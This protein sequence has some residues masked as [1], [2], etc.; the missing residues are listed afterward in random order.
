MKP[1]IAAPD[2]LNFGN[3]LK[4][5]TKQIIFT[6]INNGDTA[7]TVNSF[8]FTSDLF[9]PD[10]TLV[11]PF[12]IASADSADDI[13]LY[14][15][16]DTEQTDTTTLQIW[17]NDPWQPAFRIS[18]AGRGVVPKL[19]VLPQN[20][21]F[22]SVAVGDSL[23]ETLLLSNK[24]SGTLKSA[25]PTITGTDAAMFMLTADSLSFTIPEGDTTR[26]EL[27]VQ[28]KPVSE[29][30]KQAMLSIPTNNPDSNLTE[31]ELTGFGSL[32]EISVSD[33]IIDFNSVYI[34]ESDSQELVI[35]NTG[36]GDL[37]IKDL[38]V[39]GGDSAHFSVEGLNVDNLVSA[40][41]ADTLVI[42][43]NPLP[44]TEG[45]K[46]ASLIVASNDP[47]RNIT[48]IRLLGNSVSP[49]TIQIKPTSIKFDTT[50]VNKANVQ[51][52]T[53]RN[54]GV[55]DLVI[56]SAQLSNPAYTDFELPDIGP[57]LTVPSPDS[58][59]FPVTFIPSAV[60]VRTD[61]ILFSCN[62][63]LQPAPQIY[64]WGTA[65]G[66]TAPARI[67]YVDTSLDTLD[68]NE[69]HTVQVT[70]ITSGAPVSEANYFIRLGGAENFTQLPLTNTSGNLW[71]VNIPEEYLTFR[72]LEY[73]IQAEHGGYVTTKP[74]SGMI[75]PGISVISG[76]ATA[77]PSPTLRGQYQ[78]ISLPLF[79][80]KNRLR[81]LFYDDL[82]AYDN[83]RYR[84]FDWDNEIE[85]YSELN[86]LNAL[87][88]PGK[89]YWLITS[90]EKELTVDSAN[91]VFSGQE[92]IIELRQ[93]WNMVANPFAFAVVW[94]SIVTPL[95]SR[96]YYDHDPVGNQ[97]IPREDSVWVPFRGYVVYAK[98]NTE[99]LIAP[100]EDKRFIA[101]KAIDPSEWCLRIT[102]QNGSLKDSYNIAGVRSTAQDLLDDFD[103][104]EPPALGKHISLFFLNTKTNLAGD[105]RAVGADG[106]RFNF[107]VVSNS[108][109]AI[110][111]QSFPHNLPSNFT[112]DIIS[113]VTGVRYG[114]ETIITAAQEQSYTLIVGSKSF[115]A[116]E[117]R[118]FKSAPSVYYLTQN[119]P[120]PFNPQTRITFSLPEAAH[121]S[122][123]I[124]DITGR[125]IKS[126]VRDEFR[127][128]GHY[129]FLWDGTNDSGDAV[130]SGLYFFYLR[131]PHFSKAVKM[132]LQR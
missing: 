33:T 62:D 53:I 39:T 43:F 91:T 120:N 49:V 89:S 104:L 121:L 108:N 11:F 50:Y 78:L 55:R 52:L 8:E 45:Q 5:D 80:A 12:Q 124:Y 6:I 118:A 66:D 31:I 36:S 24:G 67:E 96:Y 84:F 95:V 107:K 74:D 116:D 93:G 114:Q 85:A 105:Y 109:G 75:R 21:D 47:N 32:P 122:V 46:N 16:P 9:F 4:N 28:F 57:G 112:W 56:S 119:Y 40:S 126:L 130:A 15:R 65:I 115:I 123:D 88:A 38:I 1:T 98:L 72:G 23:P 18:L 92:Y 83:T 77:Y 101:K 129:G 59:L 3:T 132:V 54:S 81:D 73:Y 35:S 82:G 125:R 20:I 131:S 100:Q 27:T 87:L 25:I 51:N 70:I 14:Y 79:R 102:A 113:P 68:F 111:I 64:L 97:L 58:M 60:G 61:T 37:K 34:T 69:L 30:P 29:G 86:T 17:S 7:L 76:I 42:I 127:E 71:S 41:G 106:Y 2:T 117:T 128:A 110:E 10:S 90:E 44:D 22:S 26:R 94:D 63:P 13:K 48:P 103:I 99:L 19:M